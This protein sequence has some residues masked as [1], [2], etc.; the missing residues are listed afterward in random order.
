MVLLWRYARWNDVEAQ[1]LL[2]LESTYLHLGQVH[3][4][5]VDHNAKTWDT[6]VYF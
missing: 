6:A 5:A 4:S 2:Q 3:I 1:R